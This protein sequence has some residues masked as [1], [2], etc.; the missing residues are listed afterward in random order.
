MKILL[1]SAN[2]E[3][4]PYPVFP[5]GLAYL[6][7]P[8][9][10]AGHE[11]RVLDLCLEAEPDTAVIALLEC[12][13]PALVLVSI[14][15]IDNVTWPA[16]RSY[17]SDAKRIVDLC[18]GTV[19]VVVGGSGFSLMPNEILMALGADFGV[20][21]EG[22]ELLPQL[23]ER[24]ERG[25]SAAGLPGLLIKGNSDFLPPEPVQRITTPSR[26]LFDVAGYQRDGGMAN[27]QTKRGCPFGCVYCTYPLLEGRAMRLRPINE[28]IAEIRSMRDD[29]GVGYV[30]FVDDIFNYPVDF[31]EQLCRAMIAERLDIN[32][33]AFINPAFTPPSLL[34]A[35]LSAGCDAVEFGSESGSPLMLRNLGKSFTVEDIRSASRLCRERKLD[36]AHYILFG[37]PG[38]TDETVLESF[39][40]MDEVEP[41]AVIAMTGIRIFPGTSLYRTALDEGVIR[42]ETDLLTPVFYISPHV[43]DHL[44]DLVT[45]EA[46]RRVNWVVPGL[47]VNISDAMLDAIRM[48]AVKGPLWKLV[49]RLGRSRVRPLCSP[50]FPL[51]I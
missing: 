1:L 15:N 16:S 41:T 48:F 32:W 47:E 36:Y 39:R 2:L 27:V 40:L 13:A 42:L 43:R 46:V 34:D 23:V 17:L 3:R 31:A 21:G 12:F 38:E 26:K 10:A 7:A 37:G 51:D 22:E 24:I 44:A 29:H 33:S 45:I 28:L 20:V 35:M 4:F 25:E 6:A 11:L 8:L 9:E 5:I 19:P 30:Y 18:A 49:K 14:R 50:L